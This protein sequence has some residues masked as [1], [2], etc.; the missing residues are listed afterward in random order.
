[1]RSGACQMRWLE[2]ISLSSEAGK[3]PKRFRLSR[4]GVRKEQHVSLVSGCNSVLSRN[5]PDAIEEAR[6]TGTLW[7]FCCRIALLCGT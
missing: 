1:M 2:N 3:H 6:K 5:L 4:P 7:C